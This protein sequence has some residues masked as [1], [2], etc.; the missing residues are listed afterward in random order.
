MRGRINYERELARKLYKRGWAVVRAPASGAKNKSYP[1]PDLV[2][3]KRNY[4]AVF[5]VKTAKDER[6]IYIP[7]RQIAILR[8]WVKRAGAEAFIAVKILDG[9]G[10]RLYPIEVL[11]EK[12]ESYKLLPVG[13]LTLDELEVK[14][15]SQFSLEKWITQGGLSETREQTQ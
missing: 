13:G 5:E 2:A 6:P 14:V 10:W 1:V 15:N 11:E 3:V 4:V 9:R 12:E 7:K 8:E